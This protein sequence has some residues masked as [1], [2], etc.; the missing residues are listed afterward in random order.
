VLHKLDDLVR[1]YVHKILVDIEPLLIDEDY[2]TRVEGREIILNLLNA[3]GLAHMILTMRP[4]INH[5]DECVQNTTA[6]AFLRCRFCFGDPSLPSL[7]L[8]VGRKSHGK[9]DTGIRIVQ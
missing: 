5:A 8:F 6:R 1:P 2:Y 3:A 7:K 9:Q 4:D